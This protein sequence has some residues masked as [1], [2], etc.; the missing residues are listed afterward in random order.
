[1]PR[2]TRLCSSSEIPEAGR[3]VVDV[4]PRTVGLFRLDGS[5]YAYENVCPHQGGPVCQGALLPRVVE[6][7]NDSG[8]AVGFAFHSSQRHVVCPWHGYEFDIRTGRHAGCAAIRLRSFPVTE[9][10]GEVLVEIP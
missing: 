7:L 10:E 4:G 8:A 9:A 2:G 5:L 1:M 6:N 3:L